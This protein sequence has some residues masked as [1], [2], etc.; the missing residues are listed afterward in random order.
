MSRQD[1]GYRCALAGLAPDIELAAV[2]FRQRARNS[3]SE[4]G[5]HVSFGELVLHLLERPAKPS[6]VVLSD[7]NARIAYGNPDT[8]AIAVGT[9][10]HLSAGEGEF[11]GVR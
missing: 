3:K 10:H 5:A 6:Q 9:K 8:A 4:A 11:D 2:K 7:P 1:A